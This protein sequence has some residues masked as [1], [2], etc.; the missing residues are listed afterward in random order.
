MP[1]DAGKNMRKY[2][3][4]VFGA[5]G[6]TGKYLLEVIAKALNSGHG[7]KFTYAVAARSES[8]LE[9]ILDE[10]SN[11]TGIFSGLIFLLYNLRI[12]W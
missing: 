5:T 9:D 3:L 11:S 6:F 2:D 7:E 8:R 12:G 1:S 10:V 4:I